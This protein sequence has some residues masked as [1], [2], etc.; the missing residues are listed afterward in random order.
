MEKTRSGRIRK[1]DLIASMMTFFQQDTVRAFNYQQVSN[2]LGVTK[3][4]LKLSLI[5]I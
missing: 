3:Q 4:A 2:A 1:K 5:H